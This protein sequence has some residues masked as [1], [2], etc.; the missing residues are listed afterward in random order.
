MSEDFQ[1]VP[2]KALPLGIKPFTD[3]P[4]PSGKEW[5]ILF[6]ESYREARHYVDTKL[7]PRKKQEEDNESP[8]PPSTSVKFVYTSPV[9]HNEDGDHDEE[10][11]DINN[12]NNVECESIPIA[13]PNW[14]PEDL[15]CDTENNNIVVAATPANSNSNSNAVEMFRNQRIEG[16]MKCMNLL[17]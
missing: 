2:S 17:R 12:N 6:D 9:G 7:W 10:D 15:N 8:P 3:I 16:M 1:S 5:S 11:D 14:T 4:V 13:L